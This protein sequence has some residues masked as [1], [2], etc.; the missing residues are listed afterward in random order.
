[1]YVLRPKMKSISMLDFPFKPFHTLFL[2][3][4]SRNPVE[5]ISKFQSTDW[6]FV[7]ERFFPLENI[8]IEK[9]V[10]ETNTTKKIRIELHSIQLRL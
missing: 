7:K 3:L 4:I 8:K 1:M 10:N 5:Y 2:I 9:K 6:K